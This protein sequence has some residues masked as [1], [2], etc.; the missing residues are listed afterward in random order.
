M[1]DRSSTKRLN[2][3]IFISYSH[4]DKPFACRLH[5]TLR[6]ETIGDPAANVLGH[7][8][9]EIPVEGTVAATERGTVMPIAERI[10]A[11]GRREGSRHP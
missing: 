9:P 7:L 1:R 5:N 4:A 8:H 3:T 11:G 10:E 6:D 2:S